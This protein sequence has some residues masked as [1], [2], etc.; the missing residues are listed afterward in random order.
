[1]TT[2]PAD[3]RDFAVEV[4][5]ALALA[6]D[7]ERAAGQQVYMKSQLPFHGVTSAQL[8]ALLGPLLA[9]DALRPATR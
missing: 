5:R 2:D 7:P 6:G 1:M 9:D 8:K 3:A 4:C